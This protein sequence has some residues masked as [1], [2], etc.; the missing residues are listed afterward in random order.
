MP[1]GQKVY[2]EENFQEDLLVDSLPQKLFCTPSVPAFAFDHI[3][4][5]K[6]FIQLVLISLAGGDKQ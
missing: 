3:P 5:P 2:K 6:E 4:A 1:P